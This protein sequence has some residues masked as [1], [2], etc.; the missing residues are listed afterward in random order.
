M[1]RIVTSL[2]GAYGSYSCIILVERSRREPRAPDTTHMRELFVY[3]TMAY[4][5]SF[6][7]RFLPW[8]VLPKTLLQLPPCITGLVPVEKLAWPEDPSRLVYSHNPCAGSLVPVPRSQVRRSHQF[9]A[10]RHLH[11]LRSTTWTLL[12][13]PKPYSSNCIQQGLSDYCYFHL[14]ALFLPN[15]RNTPSA[16]AAL[17]AP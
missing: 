12:M 14:F 10:K 16:R 15:L 4:S 13:H 8:Y 5:A 17:N 3:L 9:G 11:T 1:E 6:I 2:I 7:C